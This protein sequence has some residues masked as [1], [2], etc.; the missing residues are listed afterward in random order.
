MA[1]YEPA[2]LN[3]GRIVA[4][5]D[6]PQLSGFVARLAE[7][8]A[9]ADGAP[10]FVW[11][12]QTEDGNATG[13]RAFEDD[14]ILVNFSVW[15]SVES[16]QAFVYRTLHAE[17]LRNRG[18][19]FERMKQPFT[20]LWWVPSGHRPTVEE[21]IERLEHLRRHGPTV[22]AFTFQ[23]RFAAPGNVSGSSES[24]TDERPTL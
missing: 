7:I 9:V 11:R 13:L 1:E 3:I 24:L 4:P 21:A 14:L 23:R 18:Q 5:L 15:E 17:V 16:L 8:N 20:V 22:R 6:S 10:G 2:Q 12:F 19:W